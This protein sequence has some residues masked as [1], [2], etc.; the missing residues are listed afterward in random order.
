MAPGMGFLL[1]AAPGLGT[2]Q[3]PLLSAAIAYN[4]NLKA[5]RMALAGSG[6]QDAPLAVAGP[7]ALHLLRGRPLAEA[8]GTGAPGMARVQVAMPQLPAGLPRPLRG[9]DR[10]ARCRRGARRGGQLMTPASEGWRC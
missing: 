1:A 4:A 9:D 10:S 3:P 5:F 7:A 6:Q 8:I 2:V